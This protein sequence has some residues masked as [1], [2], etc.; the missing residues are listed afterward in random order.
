M[1]RERD[2]PHHDLRDR[3]EAVLATSPRE[4]G[5]LSSVEIWRLVH[6]L[7]AHQIELKLQNEE[8]RNAQVQ[9]EY[10]R[11]RYTRLYHQAP[12]GYLSLDASGVIRQFNQ[13]FADMMGDKPV[14]LAGKPLAE[15]MSSA[16]RDI[17]LS[18]FKAFFKNP[19]GKSMEVTL[20]R[21]KVNDCFIARLTGRRETEALS[22]AGQ[23]ALPLL[24]V[25]V[26]DITGQK[27]M[28]NAL[29]ER[30]ATLHSI[31]EAAQD[32]IV[33]M[34]P[35]GLI[36]FW[37]PAAEHIFGYTQDEALGL[38]LHQLLV[39]D[40][41]HDAF[42]KAFPIFQ[43]TGQGNAVGKTLGLHA[44][45]KDGVEIAVAIS[46]SAVNIQDEWHAVG[47]LRDETERKAQ[48]LELRRL[49][50]T[51]PLTGLANRRHF[52]T[53]VERELDR[54]KRYAQPA[55]LLMLDLDHFKQVND[56]YGHALG[57][58]VLKHF[59]VITGQALRK[60]DLLGRL[61]GEEFAA[62]LPD[63]TLIG[64]YPL[65]ERL[66]GIIMESPVE[67]TA[68]SI[69]FTVSI[70]VA[71]FTPD[72]QDANAILIRADRALYRAKNRGRNRVEMEKLEDNE[73]TSR[74]RILTAGSQ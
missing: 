56:T 34:S 7:S 21:S 50:T 28:E 15:L 16:D 48:E 12:E 61:G 10:V 47:I 49:A 52:L 31:T 17:F 71:L 37:N 68:G 66:R 44:L 20:R 54:F 36:S 74:R 53:Q 9:L 64:A 27:A 13:T 62:L 30:E 59:A 35:S 3:V 5:N 45:R 72:D 26:S 24:L 58:A 69:G 46:L 40:R 23:Q 14:D 4:P 60:I 22:S 41:Y 6:D 38:N 43:R 55:A 63:T 70:G 18:R 73:R 19:E 2:H 33:M 32:A 57:D 29:R 1:S 42:H 65:A 51:D 39:P 67:T 25:I 11:D 8:L